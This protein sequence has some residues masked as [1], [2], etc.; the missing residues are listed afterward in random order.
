MDGQFR[1]GTSA[2]WYLQMAGEA[3]QVALTTEDP[4]V[5]HSFEHLAL[6]W[7]ELARRVSSRDGEN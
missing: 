7:E 1:P 3:R 4:A 5:K 6:N 2:R